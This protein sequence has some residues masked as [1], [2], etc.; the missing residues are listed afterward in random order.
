M[1]FGAAEMAL[2]TSSAGDI[3]FTFALVIDADIAPC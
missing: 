3:F 1:S 2:R